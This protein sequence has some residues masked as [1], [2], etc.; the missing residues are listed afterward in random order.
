[1]TMTVADLVPILCDR[2]LYPYQRDW[3]RAFLPLPGDTGDSAIL[4]GRQEGKD[5]TAALGVTVN[6]L[7]DPVGLQGASWN[8]VSSTRAQAAAFVRDVKMHLAAIGPLVG[9]DG[10]LPVDNVQELRLSNGSSLVSHAA[11]VRS[12]VGHRGSFVLNEVSAIPCAAEVFEAALPVVEGARRNGR[13][14]RFVLIGN[15]SP[16]GSLWHAL[17]TQKLATFRRSCVP[18]SEA[19]R[20]MGWSEAAIA[21]KRAELIADIGVG[22]FMQWFECVWRVADGGMFPQLLL[23]QQ[24]WVEEEM[25]LEDMASW[26][27][28]VGLDVGRTGDPTAAVRVLVNP[29]TGAMF[30]Q[31]SLAWKDTEYATQV[32]M[33][34]AICEE[35]ETLGVVM[36][37]TGIGGPFFEQLCS[38]LAPLGVAVMPV[39]FNALVKWS[40]FRD[41]LQRFEQRLLWLAPDDLH[42]RMEL[43]GITSSAGATVPQVVLPRGGGAHADRAVALALAVAGADRARVR[44]VRHP[45]RNEAAQKARKRKGTW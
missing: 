4:G 8:V 15:A 36:D 32:D 2:V 18:W 34:R 11:S 37:K 22:A 25:D 1:M 41:L 24:R 45:N 43:D 31:P 21:A 7:C 3:L 26:P 28:V 38:G 19:M 27:Q 39:V 29:D 6:L 13:A 14:A 23:D 9:W 33:V 10:L 5:F 40:L 17:W 16:V 44:N 20:S 30:T 12:I 42:L 35:R